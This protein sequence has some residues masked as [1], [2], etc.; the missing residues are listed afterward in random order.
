MSANQSGTLISLKEGRRKQRSS[1]DLML[2]GKMPSYLVTVMLVLHEI[3]DALSNS[4][5]DY[6]IVLL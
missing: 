4:I 5:L 2:F 6:L 1:G 3:A